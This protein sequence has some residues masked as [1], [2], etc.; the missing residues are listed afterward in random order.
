M[1][2]TASLSSDQF[3]SLFLDSE[4][5]IQNLYNYFLTKICEIEL[6]LGQYDFSNLIATFTSE[7]IIAIFRSPEVRRVLNQ[8]Q[9]HGSQ[10]ELY[11]KLID[12]TKRSCSCFTTVNSGSG[13]ATGTHPFAIHTW[14]AIGTSTHDNAFIDSVFQTELAHLISSESCRLCVPLDS[15]LADIAD[16]FKDLSS[17]SSFALKDVLINCRYIAV[18]EPKSLGGTQNRIMAKSF[19]VSSLPMVC[20]FS[21]LSFK[22]YETIFEGLYHE[23]IHLRFINLNSLFQI[24]SS[25]YS[26]SSVASFEC[27]W[28][29]TNLNSS[30]VW[31]FTRAF[32][33][34]DV[35]SNLLR[36]YRVILSKSFPIRLDIE[37]V[38]RR[39]E[40]VEMRRSI[41]QKWLS[42]KVPQVF[43]NLGQLYYETLVELG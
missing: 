26:E 3:K 37:W 7:S 21:E 18:F 4:G 13:L 43:T 10:A 42:D 31:S 32:N 5:L 12:A 29:S 19:T 35:Y 28:Q 16:A 34:F 22:S 20:F 15:I 39:V 36:L 38:R 9:V 33:G 2:Q 27:P 14:R 30:N 6:S 25:S 41:L 1:S 40:E 24:Y 8:I 17:I 23:A 11:G